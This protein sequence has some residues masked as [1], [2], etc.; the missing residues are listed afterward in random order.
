MKIFVHEGSGTL[1]SMLGKVSF[2]PGTTSSS[3]GAS[4][5]ASRLTVEQP[6]LHYRIRPSGA[7]LKTVPQPLCSTEHSPYCERDMHPPV[8]L[9]TIDAIGEFPSTSKSRARST[10]TSTRR[11][12]LMSW[13]GTATTSRTR[14][15][16][17]ILNPSR[18]GAPAAA[19]SPDVRNRC[20]C[21][22]Q[23]RAA[24]VRLPPAFDSRA[25]Q[26]QQHRLG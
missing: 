1:H 14:R 4:S 2:K 5:T 15:P 12:R 8:E 10:N 16:L 26:P 24:A 11:I 7:H 21:D 9:E 18:A 23:F 19:G 20:L 25:I 17:M 6:A 13:A 22:L 3:R